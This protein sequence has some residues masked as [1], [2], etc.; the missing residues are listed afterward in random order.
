MN[1]TSSLFEAYL[2][3][4]TKCYLR[5]RA[6]SSTENA[7]AEWER[8]TGEVYRND[9]TARLKDG[10]L[11]DSVIALPNHDSLK[12][13]EWRLAVDFVARVQDWEA[14]IHAVQRVP[15]EGR[16]PPD[17]FMPLRFI[18]TNKISNDDKLLLG[19]DAFVLSE[20][21]GR[22]VEFGKIIHGDDQTTLKVKTSALV[23]KVEKLTAKIG[24]LLS[25]PSPPDLVLNRHCA[26]CEFQTRCRQKAV[27]KD[28]LSL[29][30]GMTEKERSRHRGKGIFTVSQLS[31]TFRPRRTPKRARNPGKPH[32]LALQALSIRENRIHIHG[33]PLLPEAKSRIYLDIEGLPDSDFYYLI[34]ALVVSDGQETFHGF[35]ADQKSDEPI[36]FTQ[37]IETVC[38][39]DDFRVLHYGAYETIALRRIKARLPEYLHPKIDKILERATNVLSVIHPHIYFPTYSNGLKDIGR[40]LGYRRTDESGTGLLSIVWRKA[41]ET[42][43]VPHL[44][45][46]LLQYNEDDCRTLKNLSELIERLTSPLPVDPSSPHLLPPTIRT[47]EMLK[48]R[49]RWEMF[50]VRDYTLDDF[51]YVNECAYFDYQREKVFVRTHRQF[52]VIN[53][54]HRNLRR[55]NIHPNKIVDIE[56]KRCPRCQKKDIVQIK[57]S[58]RLLIDLKFSRTGV[59]KWV[60]KFQSYRYKCRNCDHLFASDNRSRGEPRRYGHGFISWCAYSSFF[61]DMKMSRTRIALGDTFEIFVDGSRMM[62]ARHAMTAV[63]EGLYS[64]ILESLL[65]ENTLHVDETSVKLRGVKGY[66]WVLASMDKVYYF[67]KPSREGSFLQEMLRS[68]SGVL[69]SD[70]YTAY[71]SLA[72]EQQKCLVHFVRD[73][74][75]DLL[76]N[77]FDT[78]LKCIAQEFGS[79]LRAVIQTVDRYGLKSR[80]L[81]KHKPTVLRFLDSVA[82]RDFASDLAA[83]YKKRFQKSGAKMF[84][85]LD[86]DGVPWNNNNAEHAIKGFAKFRAHADGRFT[87]RSLREYLVLASVFQTCAFNNVNVLKFLLSKETT[88]D[89]LFKMAG[90]KI[91][92][93]ACEEECAPIQALR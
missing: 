44:K 62:R 1:I 3:C 89:G 67:Y 22:K 75:E 31:Y 21:L 76:K 90:R 30:G 48:H 39:L 53:K 17:Q 74:D 25:S 69:I 79:L 84:T 60:T 36:I 43:P 47:E 93:R 4:Q 45:V 81:H 68:F 18:F 52:R 16:G 91:N 42:N 49:L 24:T 26:K 8:T 61:C 78:E 5:S 27:E 50:R 64:S 32:Y 80:H 20:M 9:G 13:A 19:F 63:Y 92:G 11:P 6:E 35:W 85:F 77:P 33:N 66:V 46:S 58:G 55:T 56:C 57:Q 72:C 65:K 87:E 29:L 2:K 51:K 15:S 88:L 86:H 70:F 12:T 34:G 59:K 37:F 82:S 23:G 40:F 73:I 71:D 28:D 14:N 7:Y 41:W 83:S 10:F 54:R 38:Q